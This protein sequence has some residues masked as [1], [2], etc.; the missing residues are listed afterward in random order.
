MWIGQQERQA[1]LPMLKIVTALY[2]QEIAEASV[3]DLVF[4]YVFIAFFD[5]PNSD[6]YR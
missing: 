1:V 5:L 3:K 2:E 6:H 4:L